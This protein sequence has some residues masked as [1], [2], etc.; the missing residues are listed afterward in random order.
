VSFKGTSYKVDV[1][2]G[3]NI[4]SM[5][6]AADVVVLA[7]P[8]EKEMIDTMPAENAEEIGA[9]ERPCDYE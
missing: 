9:L 3:G 4:T 7:T 2:A 8:A 5:K 1:S 6:S